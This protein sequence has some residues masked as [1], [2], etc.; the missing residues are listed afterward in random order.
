M[1]EKLREWLRK[2]E[3]TEFGKTHHFDKIKSISDY[4]KYVPL[5]DYSDYE[6]AINRMFAGEENI[7]TTYPLYCFVTTSGS[8]GKPKRIPLTREGLAPFSILYANAMKPV[9]GITGKRLHL[10]VFPVLADQPDK[11]ML[12]SAAAYRYLFEKGEFDPDCYVGGREFL[13]SGEIRNVFYVKLWMALYEVNL[14]SIE[15]AFLYDVLLFFEYMAEKGEKMLVHMEKREIPAEIGIT[16]AVRKKLLSEYYP[17][18][19]RIR[20][21]QREL[22]RGYDGIASR[23]W[24]NLRMISGIGG[25]FFRTREELLRQFTG[26]IPWHY[27][28]YG[29][30][31][32]LSAYADGLENSFYTL[33]PQSGFFEFLDRETGEVFTIDE[34]EEQEKYELVITNRSGLYRYRQGD[35]LRVAGFRNGVPFFEIVGRINQVL[36]V[37]GEKTDAAMLEEAALRFAKRWGIDL[38]DYAVAA[39][40]AQYP[41]GYVFYVEPAWE[42]PKGSGKELSQSFDCILREVNPDYD[43][44]RNLQYLGMPQVACLIKGELMRGREYR[45]ISHN[46]PAQPILHRFKKEGDCHA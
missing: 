1:E 31:E 16:D 25:S 18:A 4:R 42:S 34:V 45:N 3:D 29:S 9:E 12:V 43:D 2:N 30:S 19:G 39:S 44:L 28:L 22:Q 32:C 17:S 23:I 14:V 27:F 40:T 33:L 13:F 38:H 41:A 46:K 10:S 15:S 26:G 8:V 37:A 36:N 21:L 24:K 11:E 7:L 6:D 5:S 35:I 20:F